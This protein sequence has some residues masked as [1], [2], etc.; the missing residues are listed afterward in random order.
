MATLGWVREMVAM[1]MLFLL[2]DLIS[3]LSFLRRLAM[4]TLVGRLFTAWRSLGPS[5][6]SARAAGVPLKTTLLAM[7]SRREFEWMVAWS[8]SPVV[9]LDNSRIVA[10]T[11]VSA[12]PM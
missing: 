1:P 8:L 10:S 4:F 2:L 3:R 5:V 6:R 11:S 9:Y 7:S 12:I